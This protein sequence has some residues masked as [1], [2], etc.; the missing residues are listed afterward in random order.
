M[1]EEKKHQGRLKIFFGYAMHTGKTYAMLQEA[2]ELTDMSNDVVVGYIENVEGLETILKGLECVPNRQLM[3]SSPEVDIDAILAR[4][5]HIV[6]IDHMA[7][8]NRNGSRH[9]KRY[10]DILEIL[11][12]GI[13]V[14][15]TANVQDIVSLQDDI[16]KI[17]GEHS[18]ETIPDYLFE[19]AHQVKFIDNE[20]QYEHHYS[21]ETLKAL[22]ELA[23]KCCAQRIKKLTSLPSKSH[24]INSEHILVCLSPSPSNAKVI[25]T[26]AKLANTYQARLTA[27]YIAPLDKKLSKKEYQYLQE[28]IS[29]AKDLQAQIEVLNDNKV[30]FEIA[31][32]ARISG[33]TKIVLGQSPTHFFQRSSLSEQLVRLAPQLEIYVIPYIDERSIFKLVRPQLTLN[34]QDF[35]RTAGM[36][37]LSTLI[38]GIFYYLDFKESNI[39]LIYILGVLMTALIT[40]RR[41]YSLA[42]SFISVLIFN[43]LFTSPRLTLRAYDS[44]YIVTFIIM[45]I[46][47]FITSSMTNKLQTSAKDSAQNAYRM[48]ILLET[49]QKL[50]K[51]KNKEGIISVTCHSL[52]KLLQR[53]I[54]FYPVSKNNLEKPL[55]FCQSPKD[56]SIFQNEEA[57]AKWVLK[58]NKHAGA[59][60]K[61][62]SNA[63]C[64]YLAVRIGDKIYGIIGIYIDDKPLDSYENNIMLSILG[65]LA[66]SLENESVIKEKATA[67]L[68]AKNEQ[69]RANLLRSISH[70]L[71]TPLTSISGNAGILL[72]TGTILDEDKKKQLY[73]DIY[74]DSLWLINLVENLLSVTRIENGSMNLNLKVELIEDVINE[75][76]KH[77][78][79]RRIQH[80]IQVIQ[81]ENILL[82]KIDARL[83][84]QVIMNILDNAI[85][86]TPDHT[87]ITIQSYLKDK[88]IYIDI[89]DEGNGINDKDKEHIFDMFYTVNRQVADSRRSLGLGLSLCQSII[90]A[91]HGEIKVYDNSPHGTVFQISLP[92]Q[93][94]EIH[95]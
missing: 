34:R 14:Y 66:L 88:N 81:D 92:A 20:P 23:I 4:H 28:N 61:T 60:T 2:K 6:L 42:S 68:K 63:L 50:Q 46:V 44:R 36:L 11:E 62:L 31:E 18:S 3:L 10:Q 7:H 49:N 65:E 87:T 64:L 35:M 59:T 55:I 80:H 39:I 9:L 70:D 84:V 13:D 73:S 86:Y 32:Y 67:D 27:L 90:Q 54:I 25:R 75:A 56:T 5:P 45:F 69:L 26:A 8:T 77:I 58:N 85:K 19:Q 78:N 95:E 48:K 16:N 76:L 71:R 53:D 91:H 89:A 12:A 74:D 21:V 33:V 41:I 52:M 43:F 51:E 93:E 94:V 40:T 1:N 57:V 38:G 15:T 22:R 82:A 24:F 83:I 47:A 72:S 17:T 37:I 29:L 79:T 30:V